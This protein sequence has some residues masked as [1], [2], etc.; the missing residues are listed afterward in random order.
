MVA[1]IDFHLR[2]EEYWR[3]LYRYLSGFETGINVQLT[4]TGIG[5]KQHLASLFRLERRYET[6]PQSDLACS[7]RFI[8]FHP[9]F[10]I[11]AQ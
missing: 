11:A 3:Y 5:N 9:Y 1:A 7:F 4:S 8:K 10:L 6:W 2:P